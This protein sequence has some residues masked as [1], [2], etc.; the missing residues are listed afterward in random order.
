MLY[1]HLCPKMIKLSKVIAKNQNNF[2][3]SAKIMLR[4]MTNLIFIYKY[5]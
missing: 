5:I 4:S 2:C 1:K 3:I